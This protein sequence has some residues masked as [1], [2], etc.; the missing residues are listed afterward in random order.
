MKIAAFEEF[1]EPDKNDMVKLSGEWE[2]ESILDVTDKAPENLDEKIIISADF[3]NAKISVGK[4]IYITARLVKREDEKYTKIGVGVIKTRIT[5]IF[6][7]LSILN[8]E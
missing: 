8:M 4:V 2:I 7:N 5:G 1:L 3:G 6:S